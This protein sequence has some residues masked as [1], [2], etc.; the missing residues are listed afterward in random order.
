MVLIRVDSPIQDIVVGTV[1][2]LAVGL[3]T[4]IRRRS[5]R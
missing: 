4:F 1:L 5:S 2:V 3:D